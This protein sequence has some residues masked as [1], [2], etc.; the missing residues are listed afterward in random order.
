MWFSKQLPS[1]H[2]SPLLNPS[3][4]CHPCPGPRGRGQMASPKGQVLFSLVAPLPP[5]SSAKHLSDKNL[6]V[7]LAPSF[8]GYGLYLKWRDRNL[9]ASEGSSHNLE[10]RGSVHQHEATGWYL[11]RQNGMEWRSVFAVIQ[12]HANVA[13]SCILLHWAHQCKS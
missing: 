6:T 8:M 4:N 13:D 1:P 3:P 2:Q 5:P 12:F 11:M 10:R 9:P 7:M